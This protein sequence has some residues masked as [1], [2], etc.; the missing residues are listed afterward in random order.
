MLRRVK[1]K[2]V[3]DGRHPPGGMFPSPVALLLSPGVERR[4]QKRRR[5]C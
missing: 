2:R 5:K 1:A 3:L 4:W